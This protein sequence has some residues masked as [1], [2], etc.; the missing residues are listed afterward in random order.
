MLLRDVID[1]LF[2]KD[3]LSYTCTTEQTNL[4]S[5]QVRLKQVDDFDAGK[6]YLFTSLQVFELRRFAMYRE[7]S[8][9]IQLVHAV[10][11]LPSNVHQT[12]FYLVAYRHGNR[13]SV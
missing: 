7:S 8:R 11:N 12:S 9:T 3:C 6:Q 2:D 13:R 1:K 5:F 4:T 10:D